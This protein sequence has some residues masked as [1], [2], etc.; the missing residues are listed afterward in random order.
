MAK[1]DVEVSFPGGDRFELI[2]ELGRGGMGVVYQVVDHERDTRI[3]LK[4]LRRVGPRAILRL[5]HEFRAAADL[6]HPN[7]VRLHELFEHEGAWFFTMELVDGIDFLRWVRPGDPRRISR[8]GT[9]GTSAAAATETPATVADGIAA[10][11]SRVEVTETIDEEREAARRSTAVAAAG[12]GLGWD[13]ANE[14]RLR[15]ALRGLVAGVAALH[16]AGMV[17]RDIKPSNV[18]VE[19]DGRV[20]LLDFGVVAE[21]AGFSADAPSSNREVVGTYSY[22]A[23][24]QATGEDAGAAAD[25][26]SVGTVLF[27]ALTGELPFLGGIEA[28]ITVAPPS[29]R[30][31]A[32]GLPDDLVELCERLL[33]RNPAQRP[34]TAELLARFGIDAEDTGPMFVGRA[35]ELDTLRAAF[36]AV[37][38]EK[39]ARAVIVAGESGIGKSAL[40][41][42]FLDELSALR[43]DVLVLAGRCDER[44]LVS[45]NALDGAVDA[46]ARFLAALPPDDVAAPGGTR[47]LLQIFPVLRG[48][49]ALDSAAR[50]D[51]LARREPAPAEIDERSLAFAAL[52]DLIAALAAHR[53]IV[54]LLDDVHWADA[55][56][57]ALLGELFAGADAP[58][59]LL[60]ATARVASDGAIAARAAV[61]VP[62]DVV[63]LGGLPRAEAEAL[64]RAAAP[65]ADA[66]RLASDAGGHPM[67]LAE[68]ARRSDESGLH[69]LRLDDAL[70]HRIGEL[71][72]DARALLEVVA[73]G[74]AA[75]PRGVVTAAAG[76]DADAFA[77]GLGALRSARLIRISGARD[78]VEPYHD[79]VRETVA[80]RLP[81]G[82]RRA[83][84][85][86]IVTGLEAAGAG[87][88]VLAYHLAQAGDG[89]RA[90]A[91]AE[92][93]ARRALDALAFD[94]AAEWLRITLE[95]GELAPERR[96]AL[97]A[98][99]A[100]VL[101]HAGRTADAADAFLAAADGEPLDAAR[102][103]RRRAAEQL[104]IG[105]H[106]ARGRE[107]AS[108]LAA[109]IGLSLPVSTKSAIMRLLWYRTRLGL[110]RLRWSRR[111]PDAVTPRD[112]IRIDVSWSVASGLSMLDSTR[113]ACFAMRLPLL[114]MPAG[115]P[116]RIARAI[117]AAAVATAGMGRRRLAERL[118]DAAH[119]AAAESD[120]P[121]AAP[122]AAFADVAYNFYL[123]NDWRGAA[124]AS[125]RAAA[126]IPDRR[127][128]TFEGDVIEQHHV[129]ALS[130]LGEI[131]ELR[132]RVPAT[133]RSAQRIGNRFVEVSHRTFFSMLHLVADRP[134]DALEDLRD[135]LAGWH[136]AGI[137]DD[138]TNP[139]FFSMKGR[140]MTALYQRAPDGDATLEADWG[141]VRA[142]LLFQIPMIRIETT[143]FLGQIAV[144]RASLA[145]ERGDAA[146]CARHLAAARRWI[147]RTRIG[148]P[149]GTYMGD[150]L[151]ASVALVAGDL[152]DAAARFTRLV[153]D[154]DASGQR[155]TAAAC[156]WR[157]AALVGGSAGAT[158]RAEAD[159]YFAEEGVARPDL[160]VDGMLPGWV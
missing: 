154:L 105:G 140:T 62:V 117:C 130:I 132:R 19:P 109:E 28:K 65:G 89:T 38:G 101:A 111:T 145:R 116:A 147:G 9:E 74:A 33:R 27:E 158:L 92:A 34:S 131:K 149:A 56:S 110:S 48:V 91:L 98:E 46:L 106:L 63:R 159:R 121:R 102:E 55:D 113:A 157:L 5:K 79:R 97:L 22:M 69:A 51:P 122:Y 52:A 23:P 135:A 2:G 141:R 60:V 80:A 125:E 12:G 10:R 41:R 160:M 58:A 114:A 70:W 115:D 18:L 39:H 47:E 142:S 50:R 139:F 138:V 53:P 49:P 156:R 148:L 93:A 36:D 4:G 71:D 13:A 26:Y 146:G 16:R 133:I 151:D 66:A 136:T 40:A 100:E 88:E 54:L 127:T 30:E 108:A 17:H 31:R 123:A 129:W 75:L 103:L 24:E 42:R 73:L 14:P 68:L 126:L 143:Q 61:H 124:E 120:D 11:V 81:T 90:A 32:A 7:L 29:P 78:F 87:V 76:L 37:V 84:H 85:R 155:A 94:R 21:V 15:A 45:Y 128:H 44:E 1:R 83:V 112:R 77:R 43:T 107:V 118:R 8:V 3:A 6:E 59:V 134:A 152:D 137:G 150:M 64:V 99:R 57:L 82:R 95:L 67:F 153:G 119:R 96:R 35:A 144:A 25:W 72:A 86:A 20:V 104:L